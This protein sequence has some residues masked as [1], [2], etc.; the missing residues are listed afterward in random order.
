MS[1]H[2]SLC[3][4]AADVPLLP[5]A[6]FP[7]GSLSTADVRVSGAAR[8]DPFL[9]R[10]GHSSTAAV[11]HRQKDRERHLESWSGTKGVRNS[12]RGEF[13]K[14]EHQS[15]RD[16]ERAG[17]DRSGLKSY[18]SPSSSYV[19]YYC[20]L[21]AAAAKLIADIFWKPLLQAKMPGPSA[22]LP[23]WQRCPKV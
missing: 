23:Q 9:L 21:A 6:S 18:L 2:T 22:H 20:S 8:S 14:E 10:R 17:N 5:A 15:V 13:F 4:G 1:F 3:D 19:N 11:M 12:E 16:G 7:H